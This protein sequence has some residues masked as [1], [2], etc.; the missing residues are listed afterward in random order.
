MSDRWR[1]RGS[2][3]MLAVAVGFVIYPLIES[4]GDVINSDWPAFA[5]GARIMVNDPGHLYDFEVQRRVELDVTGRRTL[6]TLGIK[7][8]LPFV[9]PALGAF[10]AVPFALRGTN[11]AGRLRLPFALPCL[12]LG[13]HL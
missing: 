13:L 10:L 5:T 12:T 1:W 4:E 2:V 7:G 11:A 8:I 6:V 3:A 9:A